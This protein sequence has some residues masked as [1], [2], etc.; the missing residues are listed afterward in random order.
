MEEFAFLKYPRTE[1]I[2]GSCLSGGDDASAQIPWRHLSGKFLVVEE[3]L[4]GSNSGLRFGPGKE[5]LIQSRG[6]YLVGGGRERHFEQLKAWAG[7]HTQALWDVLGNRYVLF[8]E[9]MAAKHTVFYDDLPH[10]FFEFDIYDTKDKVF[11]DTATRRRMLQGTPVVSVPVLYLGSLGPN[12]K[13]LT[14][15]VRHSLYKSTSWVDNLVVAASGLGLDPG[16]VLAESDGTDLSEGL[17]VKV[18]GG[19][20]VS[21]CYKWVRREFLQSII[22]AP[23]GGVHWL[24][25]P[26]VANQLTPGVDLYASELNDVMVALRE[27]QVL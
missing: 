21:A 4:D 27:G 9:W 17:Y 25:R 5:L 23:G 7:T 8:G 13:D 6:H 12:L 10:L 1:H 20:V 2:E 14:S 18:E 26:H 3:K 22:E 15:L 19:G 16:R 11:L 24:D